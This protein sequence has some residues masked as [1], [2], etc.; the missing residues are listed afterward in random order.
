M[1]DAIGYCFVE[2]ETKRYRAVD[3]QLDLV[4]L[5]LNCDLVYLLLDRS[6][7]RP[8]VRS[9]IDSVYVKPGRQL[10]VRERDRVDPI[11]HVIEHPLN[12]DIFKASFLDAY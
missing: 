2:H 12:F 5:E 11:G 3:G 6:G 4:C 10:I 1:L 9:H 7:K 8:Q